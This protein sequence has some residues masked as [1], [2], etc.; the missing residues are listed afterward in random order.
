MVVRVGDTVAVLRRD[1]TAYT[2][3][4]APSTGGAL[5]DVA[6]AGASI[7]VAGTWPDGGPSAP[8]LVAAGVAP[9]VV[10]FADPVVFTGSANPSAAPEYLVP[11]PFDLAAAPVLNFSY[12]FS[13]DSTV[14]LLLRRGDGVDVIDLTGNQPSEEGRSASPPASAARR[15]RLAPRDLVPARAA[16]RQRGRSRRIAVGQLIRPAWQTY[17]FARRLGPGQTAELK[18][19]RLGAAWPTR[20][21][22][23]L[24]LTVVSP[25][26]TAS[27]GASTT[28]P[29]GGRA[30][31]QP[32]RCRCPRSTRV[33]TLSGCALSTAAALWS[34]GRMA[35]LIDETPPRIGELCSPNL[36]RSDQRGRAI[37]PTMA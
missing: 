3:T 20:S 34:N 9:A 2:G 29:G 12:R 27:T 25:G 23:E 8:E 13:P 33:C 5:V 21:P 28:P 15:R 37:A 22:L 26:T 31:M 10:M 11:A 14:A 4:F 18:S 32:F 24:S 16:R 35:L 6:L 1:G 7:T 19:L 30:A 36:C 17:R